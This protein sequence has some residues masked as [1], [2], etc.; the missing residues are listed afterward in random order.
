[1]NIEVQARSL[2]AKAIESANSL[3][4]AKVA[5]K[6]AGLSFDGASGPVSFS[7]ERAVTQ[8]P[9]LFRVSRGKLSLLS[10]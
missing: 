6:L 10:K 8:T 5:E 1:M 3:E 9:G 7:K 4:T 2:I